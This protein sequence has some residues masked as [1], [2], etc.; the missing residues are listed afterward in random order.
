MGGTPDGL[1]GR[2]PEAP[3]T[4]YH[5]ARVIRLTGLLRRKPVFSRIF[6][7]TADGCDARITR[8][9]AFIFA[10][11]LKLSAIKIPDSFNDPLL[12]GATPPKFPVV[13]LYGGLDVSG[14]GSTLGK[15]ILDKVPT[16]ILKVAIVVAPL[17]AGVKDSRA[18][19]YPFWGCLAEVIKL[20]SEDRISSF[21]LCG[22]SQGGIQVYQN[23]AA[24]DW[25]IIGLIDPV[26]P[27]MCCAPAKDGL[28]GAPMAKIRGVYR[29]DNWET[30]PSYDANYMAGL[31]SN[32]ANVVEKSLK[33]GPEG[34]NHLQMPEFFFKNFLNDFLNL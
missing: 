30:S 27:S 13:I 9:M 18:F 21:S 1:P 25:K 19:P 5:G 23:R 20:V 6:T 17:E 2:F 24:K 12:R 29:R 7:L 22:F 14:I 28:L 10:P 16:D 31:K 4:N 3:S 32:G 26:T 15:W 11:T 34:Y 33:P 8:V